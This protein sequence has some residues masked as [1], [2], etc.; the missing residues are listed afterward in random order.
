MSITM[1]TSWGSSECNIRNHLYKSTLVMP[2]PA[3]PNWSLQA[4]V[5]HI[6]GSV[7]QF[8]RRLLI[9]RTMAGLQV[10]RADGRTGGRRRAMTTPHIVTARRH[11][12]D[13]KLKAREVAK[14][15]GACRND[16]SGE[17]Y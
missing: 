9:E 3:S 12:T 15:Y 10:A 7:A 17:T 6:L 5:L 2:D 16:R 11:M 14:M 1:A 13:G 4:W 8:E